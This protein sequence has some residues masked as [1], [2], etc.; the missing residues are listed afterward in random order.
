MSLARFYLRRA[1]PLDAEKYFK[2][3]IDWTNDPADKALKTAEMVL[4]LNPKSKEQAIIA[5]GYIEQALHHRP[6]WDKAEL[7]LKALE[8]ALNSAQNTLP[9]LTIPPSPQG[10]GNNT[11]PREP[12]SE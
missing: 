12:G 7:M 9:D 3:A 11:L 8:K 1:R 4:A 10:T 5:K 6:G 2:S